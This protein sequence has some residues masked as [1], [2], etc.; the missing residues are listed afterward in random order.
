M[1]LRQLR[2]KNALSLREVADAIGCSKQGYWNYE[3]GI[4]KLPFDKAKK[5]SNFYQISI[6]EI[7]A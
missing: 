1:T 6:D 3:K 5:L 2:E 4:R 7:S